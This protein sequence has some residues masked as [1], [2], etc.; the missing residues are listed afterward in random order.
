MRI[1][2]AEIRD[3]SRIEDLLLQVNML[4]H[5]GRPDLFNIGRKYTA[6]QIEEIICDES[7]PVFVA[8]NEADEV[9]GYAF[10][11]LKQTGRDNIMTDIRTLYIDDL[12]VDM[13]LRGHSVGKHI[14]EFLTDYAKGIGCYNIT[15]NVWECNPGARKFYEKCGLAPQK[16]YMEHIL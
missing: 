9:L 13:E 10:C 14:Y 8:V 11:I 4:H 2:R 3:I 15:L 12:C 1:R 7:R 6:E 16:T 5:E